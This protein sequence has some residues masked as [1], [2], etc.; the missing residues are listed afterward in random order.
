MAMMTVWA[1]YQNLT[2]SI[3]NLLVSHHLIQIQRMMTAI[4]LDKI[5]AVAY[6]AQQVKAADSVIKITTMAIMA[7]A[8][9]IETK[10]G[11]IS[12]VVANE[13]KILMRLRASI[14]V[15]MASIGEMSMVAVMDKIVRM[16]MMDRIV[17]MVFMEQM[18]KIDEMDMMDKMAMTRIMGL[19]KTVSMVRM[20]PE[21]NQA[22]N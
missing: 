17:R 21:T 4:T 22:P 14:A 5:Q 15:E 6:L 13:P 11:M 18:V 19:A 1:G 7:Q 8:I 16:V 20:V 10:S 9:P 3:Q 12:L 2:A